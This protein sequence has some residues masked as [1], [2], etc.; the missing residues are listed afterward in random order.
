MKRWSAEHV[1]R[2]TAFWN[3]GTPVL[4]IA[5]WMGC[6]ADAVTAKARRLG[7]PRRPNPVD[8]VKETA[9]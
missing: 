6:S 7:L 3:A 5:A 9:R 2:L 1:G 4:V 8:R